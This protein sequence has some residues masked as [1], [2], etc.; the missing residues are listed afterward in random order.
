[1]GFEGIVVADCGAIADFFKENAHKAIRIENI[2][3]D[4]DKWNIRPD[5]AVELDK[6]VKILKDNPTIWI[7]LGSHTDSRGKD[8]YNLN[9]SQKRAESAVGYIVSRGIDKNRIAARGYGETQLLNRC[10]NGVECTEEEH[11]L[12]RRTEFKIV[13]Y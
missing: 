13:K 6:L 2:Y 7:E 3:Y 4:F 10:S 11:Q 8:A 9:L 5:A 12:N 1:M